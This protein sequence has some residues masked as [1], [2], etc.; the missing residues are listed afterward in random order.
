[1]HTDG[2]SYRDKLHEVFM[3]EDDYNDGVAHYTIAAERLRINTG[4]IRTKIDTSRKSLKESSMYRYSSYFKG[5]PTKPR[6]LRNA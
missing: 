3:L 4:R 6:S 5:E 2:K 1:M